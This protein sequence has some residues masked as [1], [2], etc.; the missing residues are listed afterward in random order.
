[1]YST[2]I[3][4]QVCLKEENSKTYEML[5]KQV[6][7]KGFKLLTVKRHFFFSLLNNHI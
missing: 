7:S 5:L 2:Y 4:T 3:L 6:C 1:L